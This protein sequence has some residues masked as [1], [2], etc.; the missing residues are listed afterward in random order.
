MN[1]FFC[2]FLLPFAESID[3][4]I[5]FLHIFRV[6]SDLHISII[7]DKRTSLSLHKIK[8]NCVL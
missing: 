7:N 5:S 1:N 2:K 4:I 8:Y 6:E 3:A